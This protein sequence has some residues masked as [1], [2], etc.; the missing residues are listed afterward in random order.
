[1]AKKGYKVLTS[2]RI[3]PTASRLHAVVRY[4]VATWVFP[5]KLNGPLSVFTD[6]TA[7]KEYGAK[8]PYDGNKIWECEYEPVEPPEVWYD[9]YLH[10]GHVEYH[11]LDPD[12]EAAAAAV[13]LTALVQTL[14]KK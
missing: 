14:R 12:H 6:F 9:S 3:S 5:N 13:K 10:D 2:G 4:E 7:A 1:M 11:R 8:L